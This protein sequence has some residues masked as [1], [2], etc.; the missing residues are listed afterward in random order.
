M[1]LVRAGG[2]SCI[3]CT[4]SG[5]SFEEDAANAALTAAA[6]ELYAELDAMIALFMDRYPVKWLDGI[7]QIRV[8]AARAALDKARGEA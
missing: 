1:A 4:G 2:R 8:D 5:A 7:A 6:P 3:D